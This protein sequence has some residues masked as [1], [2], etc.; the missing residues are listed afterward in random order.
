VAELPHLARIVPFLPPAGRQKSDMKLLAGHHPE[1]SPSLHLIRS[2]HEENA[3]TPCAT[4]M[5][6]SVN[7]LKHF[8]SRAGHRCAWLA[9]GR[10]MRQISNI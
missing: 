6:K 3:D 4:R 2:T 10:R 7:H 8:F 9:H 1:F 5:N